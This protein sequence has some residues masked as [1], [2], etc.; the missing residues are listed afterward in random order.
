MART[1][2]SVIQKELGID[3]EKPVGEYKEDQVEKIDK[4]LFSL[5]DHNVPSFLLNRSKDFNTGNNRHVIMND[6]VF[7]VSQDVDREKK[8]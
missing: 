2:A 4:I 7:E 8:L 6:L 3:P 1:A 5:Q